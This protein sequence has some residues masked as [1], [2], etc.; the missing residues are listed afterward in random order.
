[1]KTTESKNLDLTKFNWP[2]KDKIDEAFPTTNTHPE[3]LAEAKLRGF[4][5]GHT[6]YNDLFSKLFYSGGKVKFKANIDETFKTAAWLYM[7]S[8]IG[9][10]SPKHEEKEAICALIL[11]ELCE[12][13][14]AKES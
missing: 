8:F 2:K 9:S 5:N 10:W 14:L 11:S 7:R 1:M 4:Y 12:P 13:E 6:K 3:L